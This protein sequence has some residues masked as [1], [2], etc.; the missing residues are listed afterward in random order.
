MQEKIR[1]KS[2]S[3]KVVERVFASAIISG[4]VVSGLVS[5]IQQVQASAGLDFNLAVG[6]PKSLYQGYSTFVN[7]SGGVVAGS[8][9]KQTF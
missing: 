9:S 8:I 2:G 5:P 3:K 1:S 6:G 4:W 7:V